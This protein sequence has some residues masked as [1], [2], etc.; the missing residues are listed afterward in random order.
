MPSAMRGTRIAATR[1]QERRSPGRARISVKTVAQGRPGDL[2]CTCGSAACFFAARGPW[3]PAGARP[4]LRPPSCRGRH[5]AAQLGHRMSRDDGRVPAGCLTIDSG[6]KRWNTRAPLV[7][8]TGRIGVV[9]VQRKLV[10]QRKLLEAR[11]NS[12]SLAARFPIVDR[13]TAMLRMHPLTSRC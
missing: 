11:N 10:H 6:S 5:A 1:G 4:F 3:G 9:T 12:P 2:G 7:I 8:S 13:V